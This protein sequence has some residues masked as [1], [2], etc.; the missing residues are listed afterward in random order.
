MISISLQSGSNGNSIYVEAG[1]V[2]LLFDAGIS[3]KVAKQRLASRG[4]DIHACDALIIS[5]DHSD[6]SRSA[7][8]FHRKFGVPVYM[9][10]SVHRSLGGRLGPLG[11][12]RNFA[13]GDVLRFG[14]VH[15]ETVPTPHDGLDGVAFVI[16]H[17]GKQLGVLTDLGHPFAALPSLLGRLD[18]VYLESNYDPDMLA[19][20]PY[21][22]M[23]K[24]RIR[25]PGGHLSNVEA[26]RLVADHG[27]DRLQWLA[28]SHLSEHNNAPDLAVDTHRQLLG[29]ALPIRAMSRYQVG[30]ILEV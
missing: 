8:I 22:P 9:T 24:A 4:R 6:H 1:G 10:A 26:A 19:R 21:P 3:G 23:L 18:A 11:D 7:G 5:H 15:V 13:P 30:P 25:G 28:L 20:G 27:G 2:R 12:V 17:E 29:D 16:H 14:D